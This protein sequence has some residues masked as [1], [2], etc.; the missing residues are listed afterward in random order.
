MATQIHTLLIGPSIDGGFVH[1]AAADFEESYPH[2]I[3][4]AKAAAEERTG[5]RLRW[6]RLEDQQVLRAELGYGQAAEI[7]TGYR[8][9]RV[10][11][12]VS[13]L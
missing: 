1:S 13:T 2:D 8:A 4:D 5:R 6:L 10:G 9:D 7:S 3:E 11:V 12:S